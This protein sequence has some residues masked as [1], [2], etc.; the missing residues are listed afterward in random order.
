MGTFRSRIIDRNRYSK[1]YPLIRAPKRQTYQGD[2]DLSIEVGTITFENADSGSLTFDVPFPDAN[3]QV[4]VAAR[5][6]GDSGGADV[7]L[8]ITNRTSAGLTV[9]S[10]A[11]FTGFVDVFVVKVS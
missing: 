1:R 3:Y 9:N 10:S 2:A 6:S 4:S 8:Y 5:D 7:N 11:P